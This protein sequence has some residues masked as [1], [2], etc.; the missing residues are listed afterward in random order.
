MTLPASGG[1]S[2]AQIL[3]EIGDSFPVTIPNANWRT[4]A[5][6]PSGPLVIP[7]DFYGKTYLGAT[8]ADT[9][10]PTALST[11]H[12]I[13][14]V[15][16]GLDYAGRVLVVYV[17]G[18]SKTAGVAVPGSV[19]LSSWTVGGLGPDDGGSYG[20]YFRQGWYSFNDILRCR[21]GPI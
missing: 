6:K 4:L 7:T 19:L 20:F 21:I 13:S 10:G 11:S 9:V 3:A 1:L 18:Q 15:N 2:I 8:V 14:G 12:S 5:G 16:F 17:F